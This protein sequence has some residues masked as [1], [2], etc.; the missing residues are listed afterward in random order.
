MNIIDFALKMEADG[1]AW[2]ERLAAESSKK[3]VKDIFALLA[4][5]E[6]RHYN[7]ILGLRSGT[8]ALAE[9]DV[10]VQAKN[11]FKDLLEMTELDAEFQFDRDGY[12]HAIAAEEE[13]IKLYEG[14][15]RDENNEDV[16]ALLLRIAGEEREHLEIVT[17][18]YQYME[19]PRTFLEWVEFSNRTRL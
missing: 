13:S 1:K 15:A 17:N 14:A 9:S 12:R 7:T 11:I 8:Y 10:L 19:A 18:M 2:Y 16:R 4:D 6:Q 3:D 5:A